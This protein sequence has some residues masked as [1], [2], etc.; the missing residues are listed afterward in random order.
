ME[1]NK[2]IKALSNQVQNSIDKVKQF[3][4][5]GNTEKARQELEQL[6]RKCTKR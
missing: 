6:Q 2:I 3:S 4:I 5:E 1:E